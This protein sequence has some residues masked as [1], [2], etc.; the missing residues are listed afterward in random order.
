MYLSHDAPCRLARLTFTLL[1]ALAYAGMPQWASAPPA[2][3][4]SVAPTTNLA[5]VADRL[6]KAMVFIED[7]EQ[8]L[9]R[10]TF[11]VDAVVKAVGKDP[12]AIFHWV[13]DNTNWIPYHGKLRGSVGV[14][15]DRMGNSEDRSFLLAEMLRKAGVVVRFAHAKLEPDVALQTLAKIR[16]TPAPAP[17]KLPVANPADMLL[18][19]SNRLGIS[20]EDAKAA[21]DNGISQGQQLAERTITRAADQT[22]TLIDLTAAAGPATQPGDA[23]ALDAIS[24][25]WWVQQQSGK[26]WIDLDPMLPDAEPGHPVA[27]AK[28]AIPL[29]PLDQP[30]A[31]PDAW[32]QVIA[33]DVFVEQIDGSKR[34]TKKVLSSVLHP[35]EL[36]GQRVLFANIPMQWPKDNSLFNSDHPGE[37]FTQM[38]L[39]QHE[40]LPMLLIGTQPATGF[41]FDIHGNINDKPDLNGLGAVGQSSSGAAKSATD[42]LD[43]KPPVKTDTATTQASGTLIA[44]WIEYQIQEPGQSPRKFRRDLFLQDGF[45]PGDHAD[46]EPIVTQPQQ[47]QRGLALLSRIDLMATPCQVSDLYLTHINSIRLLANRDVMPGML[48]DPDLQHRK[49]LM[50]DFGKLMPQAGPLYDWAVMR[51]HLSRSA[52]DV[53]IT[54]PTLA[55]YVTRPS[56]NASGKFVNLA[57]FDLIDV[58]VT[59]RPGSHADNF[60]VQFAQGVLDTNLESTLASGETRPVNTSEM[61][62]VSD[63]QNV[64]WAVISDRKDPRLAASGLSVQ[65]LARIDADLAAQNRVIIPTKPV[66]IAD[67]LA[68]GWWRVDPRTGQTLGM[69]ESGG[70]QVFTEYQM[71]LM[72]AAGLM[73][74]AAGGM[75]FLGCNGMGVTSAAKSFTCLGCAV[76]VAV[77][78]ALTVVAIFASAGVGANVALL[79]AGQGGAVACTAGSLQ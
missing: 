47:L 76:I 45:K 36:L 64:D 40:F 56:L 16:T 14:L 32:Q 10:D 78:T 67:Q 11:D 8:K 26:E 58:P 30:I 33:M 74:G 5:A 19:T 72:G 57:G 12:V 28:Q 59:L 20:A 6:E 1:M 35:S 55:T 41:S 48:R 69:L 21:L 46:T 24:D 23:P 77:V 70:G 50:D 44:E 60:R 27:A 22:Q 43:D 73:G 37:T 53:C 63:A 49:T 54:S 75:A 4:A 79:L 39:A 7:E 38:V 52:G 62:A 71:L 42:A 2:S 51:S 15:M 13:R 61:M 65:A 68:S 18:Q 34:Q 17:M 29:T 25:H 31:I 66:K 9:P 3:A